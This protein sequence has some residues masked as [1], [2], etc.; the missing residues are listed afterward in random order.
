MRDTDQALKAIMG[1]YFYSIGRVWQTFDTLAEARSHMRHVI[2]SDTS[3]SALNRDNEGNYY[4]VRTDIR[5]L[6][7]KRFNL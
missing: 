5:S 3:T 2:K 4:I 7:T 1:N 6:K